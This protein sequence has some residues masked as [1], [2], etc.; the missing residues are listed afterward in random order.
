MPT[1]GTAIII[2]FNNKKT[3]VYNL[4]TF[5]PLVGVGIISYSAYLW[6]QPIIA[7]SKSRDLYG[8]ENINQ[9][10]IVI[11]TLLIAFLTW[12]FIEK[13][14]RIKTLFNTK[15][16]FISSIIGSIFFIILGALIIKNNGFREIY[17]RVPPNIKWL[18]LSEKLETEG[19]I[20]KLNLYKN[21][22]FSICEF[23][24]VHSTKNIILYGDSHADSILEELNKS[25]IGNNIKG[26]K[27]I[28]NGC[29]V[30]PQIRLYKALETD[31]SEN[32]LHSFN[33]MLNFINDKKSDIIILSRWTFKMFP[34]DNHI[35]EMPYRNSEGGIEIESYRQYI[36]VINGKMSFTADNKKKALTNFI[37]NLLISTNRL[38]LIYPVPEIG[39][40]IARKNIYHYNKFNFPL[41]EISI[42]YN[43][44]YIS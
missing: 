29:E 12:H 2:I 28:I 15:F 9:L 42:P 22:G 11:L 17:N 25:F 13:P 16:I 10:F 43:D 39:F 18:S 36:S 24:D 40:D 3:L 23:G 34:V 30:V 4:L 35:N 27:I 32:C 31:M 6:H 41:Q 20:C 19:D 5:K 26:Y 44:Y 14:F 33:N 8:Y 1:L 7:F 37:D 38:Y 21:Y